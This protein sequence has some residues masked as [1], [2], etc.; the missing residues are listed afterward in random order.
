MIVSTGNRTDIPDNP[1]GS[2][3][4]LYP[5]YL[6]DEDARIIEPGT[7]AIALTV[8]SLSGVGSPFLA[9]RHTAD[10]AYQRIAAPDQP[11]PFTR[12][13]PGQQRSIKPEFCDYGGDFSYNGQLRSVR[14]NDPGLSSVSLNNLP[15]QTLFSFASGTSFAAPRVA[16]QAARIWQT[17][18]DASPNLIRTLLALSASVPQAASDIL[19]NERERLLVCG[20]GRPDVEG[21]LHSTPSRVTLIAEDEVSVDS[22]HVYEIPG[23]EVFSTTRGL[24]RIAV[25]LAFDPPTRHTRV[26]YL[27]VRM[28]FRLVRGQSLEQVV[29]SY[30]RHAETEGDP[31]S[32]AGTRYQIALEPG[33]QSRDTST[34]QKGEVFIKNN[35]REE[36]GDTYF[37]VVRSERVWAPPD[38]SHQRY[39][40]GVTLEHIG[41]PIDLYASIR[42][43]LTA[44]ARITR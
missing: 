7:A 43:R 44:R 10:P 36:Y 28:S 33:P 19:P 14:V 3:R 15:L 22:F 38:V 12:R 5:T 2:A 34:L 11:S 35:P 24:R 40:V 32:L 20:Y 9:Q 39:A 42:Q 21:A 18:P 16:H 4:H 8:G 1:P 25:S 6:L 27:G 23:P 37:L 17:L 30:R 41:T 13:G 29:A 26:D 31:P